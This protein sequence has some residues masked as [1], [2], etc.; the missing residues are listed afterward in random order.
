[1]SCD[2]DSYADELEEQRRQQ[3]QQM[4]Y[5]AEIIEHAT[6]QHQ[7][8][9]HKY[10]N[11]SSVPTPQPPFALN[12]AVSE[13]P[14]TEYKD[15]SVI[16]AVPGPKLL[17]PPPVYEKP[18]QLSEV[19]KTADDSSSGIDWKGSKV[20]YAALIAT[21]LLFCF[22]TTILVT[23]TKV[24]SNSAMVQENWRNYSIGVFTD[25]S[26]NTSDWQVRDALLLILQVSST[27]ASYRE[28]Q[29]QSGNFMRSLDLNSSDSF[30][31]TILAST[32]VSSPFIELKSEAQTGNY[33]LKTIGVTRIVEISTEASIDVCC[34]ESATQL[35]PEPTSE[36]PTTPP[37][38]EPSSV[39]TKSS[40]P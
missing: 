31:S 38:F 3:Q 13:C 26:Y 16:T 29:V 2:G 8:R 34:Y 37:I 27:S 28:V 9:L 21:V 5:E 22:L 17:L 4:S 39:D 15:C 11:S 36:T 14:P 24:R 33:R 7:Q 23:A 35:T 12:E 18:K 6:T 10:R 32:S 40:A 25:Q 20:K 1:M 19:V 30:I